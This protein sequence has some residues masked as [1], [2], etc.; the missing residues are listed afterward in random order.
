MDRRS[1]VAA[2]RAGWLME[3]LWDKVDEYFVGHLSPPDAALDAAMDASAAADLPAIAVTANQGK[4]LQL[5]ARIHGARRILEVGTLAGYST[6]WMARALPAGGELITL[7][8]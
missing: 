2:R 1:V 8:I 3:E 6:I 5:L 4:L 7:E